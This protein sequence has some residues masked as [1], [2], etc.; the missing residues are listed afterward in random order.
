M[1]KLKIVV[2]DK[3]EIKEIEYLLNELGYFEDEEAKDNLGCIFYTTQEGVF[4]SILNHKEGYREVTLKQ[5]KEMVMT[6]RFSED[7]ATHEYGHCKYIFGFDMCFF[8]HESRASGWI[9]SEFYTGKE[10]FWADYKKLN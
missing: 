6:K 4:Y 9:A 8:W 3:S 5:L 10:S 7:Q 1:E 2:Q